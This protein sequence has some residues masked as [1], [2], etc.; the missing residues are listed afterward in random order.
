M[1]VPSQ[2]PLLAQLPFCRVPPRM[3]VNPPERVLPADCAS[4]CIKFSTDFFILIDFGIMDGPKVDF[5]E[6]AP[7]FEYRVNWRR[8]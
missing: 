8:S 4:F 5:N 3:M 6:Q 2:V 1:F 7:E